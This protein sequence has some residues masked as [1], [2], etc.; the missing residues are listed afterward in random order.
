V[1]RPK[2]K[3]A[4]FSHSKWSKKGGISKEAE[5]SH[6]KWSKKGGISKEAEFSHSKWSKKGGI[7]TI[8]YSNLTCDRFLGGRSHPIGSKVLN[9]LYVIAD[10]GK[11]ENNGDNCNLEL[12]SPEENL[13]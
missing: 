6:S 5:F 7:S 4:E 1:K 10:G 8:H 12:C 13:E 2:K 11:R 3:E 9:T